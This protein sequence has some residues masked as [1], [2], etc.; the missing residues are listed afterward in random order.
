[1][2]KKDSFI[3]YLYRFLGRPYIWGGDGSGSKAGGFDCSGFVLE[4]LWA[5]GI[6]SG[7][8]TNSDGL[9]KYA[10]KAWP[11]CSSTTQ[12][13]VLF[14]GTEKQATHVAVSIGGGLMIEA[15]GGGNKCT[16]LE[17][18][19]GFVRIRPVSNRADYLAA[20]MPDF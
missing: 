11:K 12:G 19:T 18:S 20:Y 7:K 14:F 10:S 1:M 6:Y 3:K 2:S 15:G 5:F 13:A 8:D 4:G 16:F 9:R 17:N